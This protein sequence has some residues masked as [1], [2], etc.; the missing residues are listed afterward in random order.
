M[1]SRLPASKLASAPSNSSIASGVPHAELAAV[2]ASVVDKRINRQLIQDGGT[3]NVSNAQLARPS[4]PSNLQDSLRS[5][6]PPQDGGQQQRPVNNNLP[7]KILQQVISQTPPFL[8]V[9]LLLLVLVPSHLLLTFLIQP[10][11][12]RFTRTSDSLPSPAI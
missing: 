7:F 12:H 5:S 3:S 4:P 2:I 8:L 9:S 10:K 6:P 11:S 1:S